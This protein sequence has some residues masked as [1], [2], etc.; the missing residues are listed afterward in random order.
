MKYTFHQDTPVVPPDMLRT[1]WSAV[2]RISKSD[3]SIG[4]NQRVSVM[5]ALKAITVYA[6][7]QYFEEE[8]KGTIEKGKKAD[9]VILSEDPLETEPE[10]LTSIQV[11]MTVKENE[12]VYE[13]ADFNKN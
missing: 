13:T 8:E 7:Y 11:L 1:V 12:V 6:A 5:E 9:F 4:K 3:Q 10:K 2:N